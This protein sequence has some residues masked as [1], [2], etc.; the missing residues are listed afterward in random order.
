MHRAAVIGCGRIGSEVVDDER[1]VGVYSH[2]G[3]YTACPDTELVAVCDADPAKLTAC[4]ARWGAAAYTDA[5]ALL[6]ERQ[7]EIV[8][9]CT[10]E[11]THFE[12]IRLALEAPGVRAVLAEKPLAL[13]GEHAA[14]LVALAAARGVT[15]AVNHIRRYSPS[16]QTLRDRIASGGIGRLQSIGGVYTKGTLHNGSHWFDLARFMAGEVTEVWGIDARREGGPDPT[17]DAVLL[18][19][20]GAAA[21][22]QACDAGAFSL[23]EIDLIGTR[24]RIRILESGHRVEIHHVVDSPYYRGYR[25]L[26]VEFDQASAMTDLTLHAVEDLVRCVS[27]GCRPRCSGE[28]GL[29]ALQIALAVGESAR[30]GHAI[31]L[32]GG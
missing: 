29:A 24:G 23:F 15:L 17:L 27:T 25:T 9:I 26:A 18:L 13:T 32:A 28:D 2:A 30:V 11:A 1:L 3:A 12:L 8:S 21:H 22:L 20:S 10:P 31:T 5:R 7:P 4:A 19:E 14:A 6:S 16:H